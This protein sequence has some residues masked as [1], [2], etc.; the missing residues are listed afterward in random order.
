MSDDEGANMTVGIFLSRKADLSRVLLNGMEIT[1]SVVGLEVRA[2]AGEMSRV[3]L[4]L[5]AKAEIMGDAGVMFKG[6]DDVADAEST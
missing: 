2:F 3:T 5:S 1:K 6:V 4:T